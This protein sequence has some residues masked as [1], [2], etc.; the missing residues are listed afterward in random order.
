MLPSP[1]AGLCVT[2]DV[3]DGKAFTVNGLIQHHGIACVKA[4]NTKEEVMGFG[5]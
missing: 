4:K 5:R 1:F 2:W 3:A